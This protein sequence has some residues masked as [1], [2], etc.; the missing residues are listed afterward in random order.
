LV[1]LES[2]V[3]PGTTEG[4]VRPLLEASGLTAGA[5]F[6]LAHVPERFDPGRGLAQV[7]STPRVV[8][9]LTAACTGLAAAFY[10]TLGRH[11]H[12]VPTPREAEMAKLIENTFRQVN[13][14]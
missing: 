11:V 12:E 9:G 1:V 10:R 5:D 7:E 4:V 2:T 14:A 3:G 8:G 6:A 13:I